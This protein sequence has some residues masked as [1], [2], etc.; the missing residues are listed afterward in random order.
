LSHDDW[1]KVRLSTEWSSSLVVLA[2]S[3]VHDVVVC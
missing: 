2:R 3:I 1:N